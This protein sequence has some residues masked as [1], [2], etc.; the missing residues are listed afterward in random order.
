MKP[1]AE[2]QALAEQWFSRQIERSRARLGARWDEHKRG[3]DGLATRNTW[4][5]AL[6]IRATSPGR[7]P[8]SGTTATAMIQEPQFDTAGPPKPR[9]LLEKCRR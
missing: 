6:P 2:V 4:P 8:G 9:A 5:I 3:E 7:R 1:T